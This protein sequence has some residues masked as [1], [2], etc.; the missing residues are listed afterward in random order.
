MEKK[1]LN[2]PQPD[3]N[4]DLKIVPKS[5]D[6]ALSDLNEAIS[7]RKRWVEIERLANLEKQREDT[8]T[9]FGKYIILTFCGV[10]A[11]FTVAGGVAWFVDSSR[12]Q[13]LIEFIQA[14]GA[15]I[16]PIVGFVIG[17]Y[18]ATKKD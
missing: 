5:L 13:P 6:Q 15:V 12:L 16:T 11:F 17:H 3:S 7:N 9:S 18:F 4:P 2:V 1:F 14:I 8:R 10:V